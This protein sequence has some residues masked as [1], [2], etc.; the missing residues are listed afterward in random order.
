MFDNYRDIFN[1]RGAAYHQAM[2][3]YPLARRREFGHIIDLAGIKSGD[4]V[5]DAPSGGGY[6]SHF[7]DVPVTLIRVDSSTEFA[8][9]C[10]PTAAAR[11]LQCELDNIPLAPGYVDKI[12]S[13]A[14]LHHIE[15][16]K[17][18]YSEA[19]RILNDQ[20]VFCLADVRKASGVAG[21]LNE[22]V[23]EHSSLGHQG[24]FLDES[25]HDDLESVGFNVIYSAPIR[26][27]WEFTDS[28]AMT[29]CCKLM[30][31][32]DRASDTVILQSIDRY[33]GYRQGEDYC[34]MNWELQFI[35]A[36]K[37]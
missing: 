10:T 21:F 33:L 13:L 1:Q 6:L 25:T 3:D 34:E 31:G 4:V 29:R 15:D 26:Y 19:H 9:H 35:K 23:H 18:F 30:F 11:T 27:H 28:A 16:L 32:I 8:Q 20:G 12:V 7:I 24:V 37:R 2:L 36:V 17:P 22:F 5:C 14:G